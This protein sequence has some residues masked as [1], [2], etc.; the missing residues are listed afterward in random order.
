M[1]S[2]RGI[3]MSNNWNRNNIRNKVYCSHCGCE[4]KWIK[5]KGAGT[6]AIPVEPSKHFFLP[7]ENGA[8]FVMSNGQTNHGRETGD[9]L[10]G[11]K[12]HSCGFGQKSMTEAELAKRCWA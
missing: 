12:K 1:K 5:P 6:K 10:I 4:I 11:Y 7:S 3:Y 9:G 2:E 8:T